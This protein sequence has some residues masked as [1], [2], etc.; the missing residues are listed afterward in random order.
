MNDNT[1]GRIPVIRDCFTIPRSAVLSK[2]LK[3]ILKILQSLYHVS[4]KL[5]F[6]LDIVAK[7]HMKLTISC[8]VIRKTSQII[9]LT[10]K[11]P[12]FNQNYC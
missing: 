11:L 5:L 3:L 8:L 4:L 10:K 6:Q 2:L 12:S 7:F 9:K 1:A